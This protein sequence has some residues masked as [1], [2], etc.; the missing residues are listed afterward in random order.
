[1]SG[2]R[3]LVPCERGSLPVPGFAARRRGVSG[4]TGPWPPE[5]CLTP[6]QEIDWESSCFGITHARRRQSAV[7]RPRSLTTRSPSA[8]PD[9][10]P[11]R[12]GRSAPR[13]RVSHVFTPVTGLIMRAAGSSVIAETRPSPTTANFHHNV[14]A[15]D[16]PRGET[17][18]YRANR[19]P[20]LAGVGVY[21][22]ERIAG[23]RCGPSLLGRFPESTAAL[24]AAGAAG[25][26]GASRSQ[27]AAEWRRPCAVAR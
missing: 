8:R 22:S 13:M 4:G 3:V 1:L 10:Q 20:R 14:T 5:S 12:N 23:G 19:G 15:Q 7:K 26:I 16:P 21:R 2:Q 9:R 6:S 11:M 24:A 25:V 27:A 17:G 18:W